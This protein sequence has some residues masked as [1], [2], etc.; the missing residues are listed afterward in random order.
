MPSLSTEEMDLLLS[1]AVP[2]EQHLRTEFLTAVAAERARG[3]TA[4]FRPAAD[5]TQRT[6]PVHRG[7]AA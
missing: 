4:L 3:S 5:L 2:I 7:R 1:L 6:A